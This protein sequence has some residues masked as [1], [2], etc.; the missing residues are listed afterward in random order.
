MELF[1]RRIMPLLGVFACVAVI[2]A[3]LLEI[4]RR[5]NEA[6]LA[7]APTIAPSP[8]ETLAPPTESPLETEATEDPF[9]EDTETLPGRTEPI[10]SREATVEPDPETAEPTPEPTAE[11]PATPSPTPVLTQAPATPVVPGTQ[12]MPKSGGGAGTGAAVVLTLA[13]LL[14]LAARR[15]Y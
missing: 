11:P 8:P 12:P 15:A 6:D 13:L 1:V 10:A 9:P 5:A 4:D 3:A 14:Q 2:V 7:Q